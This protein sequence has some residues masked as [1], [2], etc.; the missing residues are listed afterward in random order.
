MFFRAS[1]ALK[2]NFIKNLFIF[3]TDRVNNCGG[4]RTPPSTSLY[5]SFHFWSFVI[6]GPITRVLYNVFNTS[7]PGEPKLASLTHKT[8]GTSVLFSF[9]IF[10]VH[11]DVHCSQR[12]FLLKYFTALGVFVK[13]FHK[14][15][16]LSF[17]R[18]QAKIEISVNLQCFFEHICEVPTIPQSRIYLEEWIQ[19]Q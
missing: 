19:F 12:A 6:N 9:F 13:T 1:I 14:T 17:K 18:I 15:E 7:V 3:T 5:F 8:S 2:S 16:F 4:R 10:F 11:E